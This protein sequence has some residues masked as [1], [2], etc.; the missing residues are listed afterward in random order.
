MSLLVKV[1]SL[2]EVLDE[3]RR[4]FP[5][6]AVSSAPLAAA[7]VF[8]RVVHAAAVLARARAPASAA[9][10][11]AVFAAAACQSSRHLNAAK[12]WFIKVTKRCLKGKKPPE[13]GIEPEISCSS[14]SYT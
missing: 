11:G 2:P 6:D 5:G 13:L 4:R 1:R 10:R 12:Q 9:S 8:C 7:E 14:S 3:I